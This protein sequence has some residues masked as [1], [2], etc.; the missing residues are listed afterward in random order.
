MSERLTPSFES[1][2]LKFIREKMDALTEEDKDLS[3]P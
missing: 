1:S 2:F 3:S